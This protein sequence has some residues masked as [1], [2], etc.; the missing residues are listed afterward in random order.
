MPG[1]HETH[2]MK[3]QPGDHICSVYDSDAQLAD[4]AAAFLADGLARR[5][6]CW[7]VPSGGETAAVRAELERRGINVAAE[8]RRSSLRLLDSNDVYVL[9][10]FDPEQTMRVF[11]DAIEEAL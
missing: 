5:E 10:D 9:G 2:A 3:L 1:Q 8:S 4:T 6:R 7:Y 11:S